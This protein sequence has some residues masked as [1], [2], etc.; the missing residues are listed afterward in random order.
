MKNDWIVVSMYTI[1]TPYEEEVQTLISSLDKWDIEYMVYPIEP[2]GSWQKNCQMKAKVV[3]DALENIDKNIVWLDADAEVHG[4][5]EFFN[6]VVGDMSFKRVNRT[7]KPWLEL[8]SGT[9]YFKNNQITKNVV[10]EWI[11]INESN[12][13]LDQENLKQAVDK[14]PDLEVTP[15][16]ETYIVVSPNQK[17]RGGLITHHQA[18]RRFKDEVG[19]IPVDRL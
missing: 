13:E 17:G 8:L 9:I 4:K 2:Q 12:I 3:L 6:S 15:L 18:S 16:P 10:Q 19:Y 11:S 7:D 5:L 14:F 1:D